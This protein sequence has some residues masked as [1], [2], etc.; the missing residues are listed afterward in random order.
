MLTEFFDS[1]KFESTETE[2]K[3]GFP[4]F[5]FPAYQCQIEYMEKVAE[6]ID[7]GTYASLESPGGTGK[8]LCL[9]TASLGWLHQY[10]VMHKE[11]AVKRVQIVYCSQT[12]SQLA[13]VK[14]ELEKTPFRPRTVT[15][16]KPRK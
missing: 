6:S 14:R 1:K 2:T 16:E 13:Q 5:P 3:Q 8:T 4:L 11:A 12:H 10:Y 7:S 15:I 9:L